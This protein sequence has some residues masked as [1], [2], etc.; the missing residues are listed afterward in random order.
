ML[1]CVND[2]GNSKI[3]SLYKSY[4]WISLSVCAFVRMG[5]GGGG[6]GMQVRTHVYLLLFQYD[7]ITPYFGNNPVLGEQVYV[8]HVCVCMHMHVIMCSGCHD[9]HQAG[10]SGCCQ[11]I[12]D[13][14]IYTRHISGEGMLNKHIIHGSECHDKH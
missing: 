6:S 3:I 4:Q 12:L 5:E 2:T 11:Y 10:H 1:R 9:T 7:V 14:L 8:V 13:V